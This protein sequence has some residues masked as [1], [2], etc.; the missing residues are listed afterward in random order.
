[1]AL[2]P[3]APGQYPYRPPY[4]VYPP[5]YP[6]AYPNPYFPGGAGYGYGNALSGAADLNRSTGDVS[7][8]YEQARL[9]REQYNQAQIDTKRKAFDELNYEKANTPT[10]TQTLTA[11]KS[12]I[13]NRLMN[14][15]TRSEVANGTTLNTL[16]PYLQALS[17]QGTLGPPI[18][19][20]QQPLQEINVSVSG[21]S[22]V[23][24]FRDVGKISWPPVLR[25]P[26]QQKLDELLPAAYKAVLANNLDEKLMRQ[27]R[28]EM[29]TLRENLRE[30]FRQDKIEGSSYTQAIEFYNF[31][32]TSVN[33]L[34]RSDARQQLDGEYA[35][36]G[37]NVQEIVEYMSQTGL[38]FAPAAP[39]QG[40]SYQAVHDAFVRY[41]RAAQSSAGVRVG[42]A[43]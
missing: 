3:I 8:Q 29:K 39:G 16:L 1:M 21:S 17:S 15:P 13:L 12:Q 33:A 9:M 40:N 34:E 27:I 32:E 22:S 36:R 2:T 35:P 5:S 37:R 31:L 11:E 25:S 43:R 4:P 23:G 38:R 28:T 7:V 26:Q 20:P 41:A 24:I 14:F 10:Y 30:Q 42:S 19:V 6:P 18:A